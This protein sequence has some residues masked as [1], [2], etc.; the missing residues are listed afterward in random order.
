MPWQSSKGQAGRGELGVEGCGFDPQQCKTG[1]Q[2]ASSFLP[3]NNKPQRYKL[4]RARNMTLKKELTQDVCSSVGRVFWVCSQHHINPAVVAHSYNLS[5]LKMRHPL[6]NPE[7]KAPWATWHPVSKEGE[8]FC[9]DCALRGFHPQSRG[10]CTVVSGGTCT[11]W[12]P[13][14]ERESI[15]KELRVQLCLQEHALVT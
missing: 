8:R 1:R 11:S 15:R 3:C 14:S 10:P 5:T 7:S 12:Q 13:G 4:Q 9:I 6:L 2:K